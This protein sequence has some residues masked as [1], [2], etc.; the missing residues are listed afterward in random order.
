MRL[1]AQAMTVPVSSLEILR[2]KLAMASRAG[3]IEDGD[4]AGLLGE[5]VVFLDQRNSIAA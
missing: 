4:F 2:A 1:E 3:A 5:A